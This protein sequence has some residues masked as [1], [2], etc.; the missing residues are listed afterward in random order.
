MGGRA[1]DRLESDWEMRQF[2]HFAAT[3]QLARSTKKERL[4]CQ[5]KKVSLWRIACSIARNR[6]MNVFPQE[7]AGC[8]ACSCG[9][10]YRLFIFLRIEHYA[11]VAVEREIALGGSR[12]LIQGY[13]IQP[14][15][16]AID[17]VKRQAPLQECSHLAEPE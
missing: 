10:G 6:H 16:V 17:R 14:V 4:S 13:G 12:H 15:Q 8:L 3:P 9:L 1:A 5:T 2:P 11:N 7:Q